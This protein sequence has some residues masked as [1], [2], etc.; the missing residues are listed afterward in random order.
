MTRARRNIGFVGVAATALL[1]AGCGPTLIARSQSPEEAAVAMQILPS[2]DRKAPVNQP[3]VVVAEDGTLADVSVRGPK[4]LMK[5][6]YNP[7][8]NTWT[9]KA[10]TL[11]FNAKYAVTA[12]ATNDSGTPTTV[13][14]TIRTVNPQTLV[15][16]SAVSV[17]DD[18]TVG[19]GMPIRVTFSAPVKN[20]KAVEEQLQVR[21][22]QPVTGAWSW[23][24]DE[25]VVFRPK[26]YWP[27]KTDI[28]VSMPLKGVKAGPGA[29]GAENK[30]IA[31]RTGNSMVSI[32]NAYKHT[33][34][35][36]KNGK[37]IKEFPATS[38]KPGFETRQGIKVI[39]EK[40]P[41]VVMDAA[42]GGTSKNDPEY[43]RLDVNWAMRITNSGEFVHAA[44]WSVGSQGYANVSHGCIGLSTD[45]AYWLFQNSNIGDIVDVR[46]TGRPQDLG[47]GITDWNVSW[48][49]WLQKS[50]TGAVETES[51]TSA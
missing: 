20:K 48:K 3:L 14:R 11:D 7:E 38:G 43:Y 1:A 27:A 33:M 22:S 13:E 36:K 34:T 50:K 37:V 17:A 39:T 47:N 16:I 2:V 21:T 4:G 45:N 42:T 46:N 12:T 23:E 24:S 30:Q 26:K 49:D 44:P 40:L 31:Y 5:G 51:T 18:A 15:S 28:E 32:Y 6:S 10:A 29:Y 8:R 19:V 41:F 9:S 35:V 25:V